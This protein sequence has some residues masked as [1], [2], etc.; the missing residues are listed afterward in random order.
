MRSVGGIRD[1]TVLNLQFVEV[2][3][4]LRDATSEDLAIIADE[5]WVHLNET[6]QVL[7]QSDKGDARVYIW[8]CCVTFL[9]IG[10]KFLLL[11]QEERS[12]ENRE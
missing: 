11:V 3:D 1:K 12:E 2:G 9:D 5:L 6:R 10:S 4:E 7:K 8:C